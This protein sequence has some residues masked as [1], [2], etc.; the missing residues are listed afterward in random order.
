MTVGIF[1][2]RCRG[3]LLQLI[4]EAR[5]SWEENHPSAQQYYFHRWSYWSSRPLARRSPSTVYLPAGVFE[6]ILGDARQ[7]LESQPAFEELGVP[8]RRGYLFYGPPGCGKTTTVIALATALAR[9]LYYLSLASVRNR[10]DLASLLDGVRPGSIVLIE[11]VDCV[12]AAVERMNHQGDPGA[13]PGELTQSNANQAQ[14]R[15]TTSDLLNQID[16]VVASEGRILIMTTNYPE[17]LDAALVR[18]GRVDRRWEI[19]YPA[20]EQLLRFHA[21]AVSLGM[22]RDTT[23]DFL[24][25]LGPQATIASAQTV[26][27]QSAWEARP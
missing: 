9:P 3:L 13:K 22:T 17:N 27:F 15:L 21:R 8:Y 14:D 26:I 1:P 18:P 2:T 19:G 25:R 16:G 4:E 6:D 5:K 11:D 7:F 23:Q 12:S 20:T 24:A 10:D